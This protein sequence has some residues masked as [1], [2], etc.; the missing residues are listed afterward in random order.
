MAE[1]G[2]TRVT[3]RPPAQAVETIAT[4]EQ[5]LDWPVVTEALVTGA[6]VG[7]TA[8]EVLAVVGFG[9]VVFDSVAILRIIW[10]IFL[11]LRWYVYLT[12]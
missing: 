1:T 11:I 6:T 4:F 2:I 10:K 5:V 12:K 7:V 3:V 8:V 9:A